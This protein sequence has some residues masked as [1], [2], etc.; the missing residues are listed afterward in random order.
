MIFFQDLEHLLQFRLWRRV[1]QKIFGVALE[2]T[3]FDGDNTDEGKNIEILIFLNFHI[4]DFNILFHQIG[5]TS[6]AVRGRHRFE[7]AIFLQTLY[8]SDRLLL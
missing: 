1:M 5:E 6:L 7:N 3:V 2:D 8:N 4:G